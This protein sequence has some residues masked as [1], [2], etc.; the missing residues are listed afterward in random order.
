M[1]TALRSIALASA[2]WRSAEDL[3]RLWIELSGADGARA[4]RAIRQLGLTGPRGAVFLKTRFKGDKP[5]E[6]RRIAQLIDD[7]DDDKFATREKASAELE[8]L[9][10]RAA[11]ALRRTLE[12][13]VSA[14]VRSRVKRLLERLDVPPGSPPSHELIRLRAIEALEANGSKEA[15]QAL[16]ELSEADTDAQL[17]QEA[18]ASLARLRSRRAQP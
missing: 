15:R 11:T 5:P 18:K 13:E 2:Y 7:L 14:E 16:A 12:G 4:Y 17:A 10:I 3:E 8:K 1:R 6:E 9:G